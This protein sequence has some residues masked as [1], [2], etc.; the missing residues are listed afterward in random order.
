MRSEVLSFAELILI[1]NVVFGR[2]QTLFFDFAIFSRHP[3]IIH[4]APGAWAHAN[5]R[6]ESQTVPPQLEME[7]AFVR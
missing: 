6:G 4:A 2:E 3:W 5:H 7:K 1:L